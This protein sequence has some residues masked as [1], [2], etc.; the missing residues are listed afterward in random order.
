[1][2]EIEAKFFP[3]GLT[4]MRLTHIINVLIVTCL[5]FLEYMRGNVSIDRVLFGSCM[6]I[7]IVVVVECVGVLLRARMIANKEAAT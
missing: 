5:L 1:M 6:A 2:M 7:V 3:R 4:W